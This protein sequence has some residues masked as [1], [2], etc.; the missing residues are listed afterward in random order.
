MPV[1]KCIQKK[2]GKKDDGNLAVLPE[3]KR[4][5]FALLNGSQKTNRNLGCLQRIG[6]KLDIRTSDLCGLSL[7]C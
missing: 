3:N 7:S 6:V 5:E 2:E 4:D 1:E